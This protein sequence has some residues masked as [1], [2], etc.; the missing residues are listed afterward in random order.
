MGRKPSSAAKPVRASAAGQA[1]PADRPRPTAAGLLDDPVRITGFKALPRRTSTEQ[2]IEITFD[3]ADAAFLEADNLWAAP[4]A[5]FNLG[6]Q[7][8]ELAA[9][10]GFD[11]LISLPMVR[12]MQVLEHQVNTARTALGQMRGRALLADE[13]GLGKTIEAGLVLSELMLRGL[14]RSVLILTP[15]SLVAQWRA[16]LE[17]KFSIQTITHDDAE[18]RAQG[19]K[20]WQVY[21]QILASYHTAKRPQHREVIQQRHWDMV[22][23]DEA[24]HLRNRQTQLW[25]FASQLTKRY[26]L[27]LTA[28]PVQNHLEELFNLVTLL[29]P[30]L[31]STAKRFQK[32]FVDRKDKLTPRNVEQLQQQVAQVMVRNRRATVGLQFTRRWASTQRVS[33]TE[34]ER[35]LYED[36]AGQVRTHLARARQQVAD[37][38]D[39]AAAS[40]KLSR[41]A[42]IS[43]QMALGSSAAAAAPTLEKLSQSKALNDPERDHWRALAHAAATMTHHSKVDRLLAQLTQ[44]PEKLVVFT[45]FR[46]TQQLLEHRLGDAGYEVASFHGGLSRLE[47]ERQVE[48]FRNSAQVLVSTD[49]GSEGRNLQFC[50]AI[51]NFDLPWNPQR[52]EQRIGR[53][54]RIGQAHDVQVI[55]LVAERTIEAAVLH[56]LDAKLAM[57][58]LVIGEIDMVLSNL[59]ESREFPDMVA[60]V[61]SESSDIDDFTAR[62]D[63]L[64][65]RLLAAKRAY[66]QQRAI[67]DQLFGEAMRPRG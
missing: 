13:V 42:L 46:Q 26:T 4:L 19:A 32:Q 10:P 14:V 29:E 15:P 20:A 62:L 58:E 66:E 67:E 16:E 57:F 5:L 45:Q 52:I 18:F 1:A 50:H 41:M 7:A 37:E 60:D 23:I 3:A 54:S 56:L 33:Q 9:Q 47:K 36:V 2:G 12:D 24:H 35:R 31:L 38:P 63:R 21:D 59:D 49:A 25:K 55:N 43:L 8:T 22:I 11:R 28:T 27:L 61:F 6:L 53:L 30:G 48:H 39:D 40:G 64:G 17:R 34:P 44:L 65:D 51:C